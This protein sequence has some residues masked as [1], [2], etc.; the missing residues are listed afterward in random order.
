M[1]FVLKIL[2]WVSIILHEN[3]LQNDENQFRFRK[4]SSTDFALRQSLRL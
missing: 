1:I 4:G 3:E 2:D